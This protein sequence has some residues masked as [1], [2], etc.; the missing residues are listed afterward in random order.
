MNSPLDVQLKG[1]TIVS[2][3]LAHRNDWSKQTNKLHGRFESLHWHPIRNEANHEVMLVRWW[4]RGS[5]IYTFFNRLARLGKII[6][7]TACEEISR[8][9][10][11]VSFKGPFSNTVRENLLKFQLSSYSSCIEGGVQ[12]WTVVTPS[13]SVGEFLS[14]IQTLGKVGESPTISPAFTSDISRIAWENQVISKLL[15]ILLTEKEVKCLS[16]AKELGYLQS[17]HTVT[18]G[19]IASILSKNK[20]TINRELRSGLYKIVDFLISSRGIQ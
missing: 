12:K 14:N 17:V 5:S 8:N 19:D 2:F 3:S 15:M 11:M 9:T 6:E 7:L 20:S 18:M 1:E 13:Y 16:T 10:Y 4:S